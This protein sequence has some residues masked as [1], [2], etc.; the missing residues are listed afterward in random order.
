MNAHKSFKPGLETL[1]DRCVPAVSVS[2]GGDLVINSTNR[3]DSVSVMM[4]ANGNYRVTE[5]GVNRTI[6]GYRVWGGDVVFNG[7][8]GNDTFVNYTFLRT[9][10]RGGAG[11]DT[12]YAGYD[13]AFLDGGAGSDL[14]VGSIGDDDL[15]GGT[16]NDELYGVDGDDYLNGNAGSD[17]LSGGYGDDDLDGGY[18]Y[19]YDFAWGHDGADYFYNL[20][21]DYEAWSYAWYSPRLGYASYYSG[22]VDFDSWD[23]DASF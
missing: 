17:W 8:G 11:N 6:A 16:G 14:L 22:D 10:A 19:D 20:A 23:G 1:E 18:D 9:T 13:D 5:N 12:L 2:Y 21:S 3:S 15:Y 7:Y 4:L